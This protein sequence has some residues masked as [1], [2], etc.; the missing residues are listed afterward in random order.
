GRAAALAGATAMLDVSD[1][2][3][4]DAGRLAEA[5]GVTVDISLELLAGAV[6]RLEPAARVTGGDAVAW[7][8][9]GGEDHGMLA[10]FPADAVLPE[11]FVH[12]GTVD[13]GAHGVVVDG[14]PWLG[15]T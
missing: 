15:V 4:L 2:L 8:L 7:V 10:T 14:E 1:G 13:S 5:S 12:V 6:A 3:L 9:G 11:P